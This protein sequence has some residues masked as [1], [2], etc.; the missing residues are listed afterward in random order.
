MLVIYDIDGIIC[1]DYPSHLSLLEG[2]AWRREA[3][4]L[5]RPE[6]SFSL[7]TGRHISDTGDTLFWL[8]KNDLPFKTLWHG[9]TDVE[10]PAAYKL[11]VLQELRAKK[12]PFVFYESD[13]K[14]VDFLRQELPEVAD[15]IRHF[16]PT[17]M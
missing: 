10:N 14:T 1:A 17:R 12:E 16:N 15:M 7:L 3:R 6:K 4:V 2:L 5:F 13:G 9:N 11:L 8:I